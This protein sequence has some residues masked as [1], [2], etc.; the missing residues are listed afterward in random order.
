[1]DSVSPSVAIVSGIGTE[2]GVHWRRKDAPIREEANMKSSTKNEIAGSAHEVK[3][4]I[5]EEAGHLTN[6]PDLEADGTGE[7]VAGKVQKKIGELE[8][9]VGLP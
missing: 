3:G 8:K 1:M 4:K 2:A 9:V 5:K 6:N 7:K